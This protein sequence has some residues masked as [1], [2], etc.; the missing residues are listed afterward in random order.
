MK[1]YYLPGACSF[2]VHLTLNE[3]EAEFEID[4]VDNATKTTESGTDFRTVNPLGYVPALELDDGNVLIEAPAILQHLA[5][6]RP[7]AGLAPANKTL[8]RTRM[9]QYLNFTASEFHKSFVPFFSGQDLT[10]EEREAAATKVG[11][12][13]D[14]IEGLLADGREYLL[15]STF[16]VADAYTYTVATWTAPTGIG[17]D[18]WPNIKAYVARIA[19]RPSVRKA[20]VAEGL[21]E[22]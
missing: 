9:Q 8:E 10:A 4:K 15:G 17:L 16:T 7:D 2:A 1:L 11:I 19:A 3:L 18:K 14:Y 6:S 21:S 12:R 5:D 20:M 22:A 13:L